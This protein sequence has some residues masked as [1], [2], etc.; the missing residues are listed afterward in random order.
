ML[1]GWT[2]NLAGWLGSLAG[3]A[4]WLAGWLVLLGLLACWPCWIAGWLSLWL[5]CQ[6]GFLYCLPALL[7]LL[8]VCPACFWLGWQADCLAGCAYSIGCLALL[9]GL[10]GLSDCV[11]VLLMGFASWLCLLAAYAC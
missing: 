5:C 9:A 11:G 2:C 6:D 4:I 7:A 3:W 10:T 8:A 1:A